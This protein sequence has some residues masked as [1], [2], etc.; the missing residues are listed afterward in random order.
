MWSQYSRV[1]PC[2][3][4]AAGGACKEKTSCP[5]WIAAAVRFG[6]YERGPPW[7]FAETRRR[8]D[9]WIRSCR[10]GT[11]FL[12]DH[13]PDRC[14]T[15]KLRCVL[16]V[17][18]VV[19]GLRSAAIR[20]LDDYHAIGKR[21]SFRG[22]DLLTASKEPATVARDDSR[23]QR[24]IFSIGLGIVNS[25]CANEICCQ[26][27]L[28]GDFFRIKVPRFDS[29]QGCFNESRVLGLAGCLP[30]NRSR[31]LRWLG[32]CVPKTTYRNHVRICAGL[33]S[34]RRGVWPARHH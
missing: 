3:I 22:G 17:G 4:L 13:P 16:I 32:G 14:R 26:R 2:N 31:S 15:S 9:L 11:A 33:V 7:T 24:R 19:P 23:C 10:V 5:G 6:E 8:S 30:G 18:V 27:N 21:F 20:E 12:N 25:H 29:R 28:Q 1:L 34:M